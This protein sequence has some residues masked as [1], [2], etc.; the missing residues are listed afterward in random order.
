MSDNSNGLFKSGRDALFI[1]IRS[2]DRINIQSL[3]NRYGYNSMSEMIRDLVNGLYGATTNQEPDS[4]F[5]IIAVT[6]DMFPVLKRKSEEEGMTIQEYALKK[7]L[8]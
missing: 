7:I 8:S 1:R 4:R 5:L 6:K 3:M 2:Y